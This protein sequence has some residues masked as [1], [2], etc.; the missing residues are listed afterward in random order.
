MLLLVLLLRLDG[1][2]PVV[3]LNGEEEEALDD[4]ATPARRRHRGIA[5]AEDRGSAMTL[6]IE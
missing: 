1:V 4:E 2:T 5:A 3:L 6:T